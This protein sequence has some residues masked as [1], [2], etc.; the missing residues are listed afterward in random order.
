[1]RSL[2]LCQQPV[3]S[4]GKTTKQVGGW[5]CPLWLRAVRIRVLFGCL[6]EK[7]RWRFLVHLGG[8]YCPPGPR[9]R[10]VCDVFCAGGQEEGRRRRAEQAGLSGLL[11]ARVR[12]G[13][14]LLAA[15][16]SW[17][18]RLHGPLRTSLCRFG[19]SPTQNLHP[20]PWF[21]G[22]WKWKLAELLAC[23][24]PFPTLSFGPRSGVA[25]LTLLVGAKGRE[26]RTG[27][28]CDLDGSLPDAD[29]LTFWFPWFGQ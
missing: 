15:A 23:T 20:S 11:F 9:L 7:L 21:L 19:G 17:T 1:M 8:F 16:N 6:L 29:L 5:S 12:L 22:S 4:A 14:L 18:S 24:S 13:Y 28:P 27:G 2:A 3:D 25:A 26:N 10:G